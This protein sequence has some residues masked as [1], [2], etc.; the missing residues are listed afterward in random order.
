MKTIDEEFYMTPEQYGQNVRD[1]FKPTLEKFKT[2]LHFDDDTINIGFITDT[3]Y[4]IR[5]QGYFGGPEKIP[6]MAIRDRSH[7]YNLG[8]VS[9]MLDFAV[10]GGDVVDGNERTSYVYNQLV[11]D[12]G[13]LFATLPCPHAMVIGNHDNNT[14]VAT[15]SAGAYRLKGWDF[16]VSNEL[17]NTY[18]VSDERI[19]KQDNVNY[20]YYDV[21]G[22]RIIGLDSFPQYH[23]LDDNGFLKYPAFTTSIFDQAQVDWLIDKLSTSM[24][25]IIFTHCPIDGTLQKNPIGNLINH[26]VVRDVLYSKQ[27]GESRKI[28]VHSNSDFPIETICDFTKCAGN[29]IAVVNGHTHYDAH[30]N[31]NDINLLSGVNSLGVSHDGVTHWNTD[32]EDAFYVLEISKRNRS[33][34]VHAYGRAEKHRFNY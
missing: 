33:V 30:Q 29:M 31:W 8:Y 32:M 1:V 21:K 24:P 22:I 19:N 12:M 27:H 5:D 34:N 10:H 23:I 13:T 25:V 18:F 11:R 2:S 26:N 16:T 9:D 3:H 4:V 15:P 6:G 14:N 7:L 20:W 28:S 17:L